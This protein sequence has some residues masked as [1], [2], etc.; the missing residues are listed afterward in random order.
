MVAARI[1]QD[2]PSH[3]E[4]LSI[5]RSQRQRLLPPNWN[6]SMQRMTKLRDA[7]AGISPAAAERLRNE[8]FPKGMLVP[9]QVVGLRAI[10]RDAIAQRYIQFRPSRKQVSELIRTPAPARDS[11]ADGVVSP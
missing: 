1:S 6:G 3:H 7:Y 4:S 11:A 5:S 9:D 10:I 8:F 2:R